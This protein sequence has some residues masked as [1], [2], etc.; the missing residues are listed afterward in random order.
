MFKDFGRKLQRDVKRG[1]DAR[2]RLSEEL[3]QGRIKV[4]LFFC[5]NF[6]LLKE[7]FTANDCYY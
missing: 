1:V 5:L 4:S 2:L 6:A 7:N 3:S